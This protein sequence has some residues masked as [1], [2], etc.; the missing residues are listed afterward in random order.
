[1]KTRSLVLTQCLPSLDFWAV[2]LTQESRFTHCWAHLS[3][4]VTRPKQ[5]NL[6]KLGP[7]REYALGLSALAILCNFELS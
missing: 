1:M 5:M 3:D 6:R 4:A 7:R 2:D